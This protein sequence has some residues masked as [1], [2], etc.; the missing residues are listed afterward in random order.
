MEVM[1]CVGELQGSCFDWFGS[2]HSACSCDVFDH[3]SPD[4]AGSR[5]QQHDETQV[6]CPMSLTRQYAQAGKMHDVLHV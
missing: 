2:G 6:P 1:S 5:I 4:E 3:T